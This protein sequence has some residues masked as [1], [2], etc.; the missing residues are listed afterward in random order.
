MIRFYPVAALSIQF[1]ESDSEREPRQT[2]S[3]LQN[4]RLRIC[5]E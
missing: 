5:L 3:I 2:A 4:C 1:V